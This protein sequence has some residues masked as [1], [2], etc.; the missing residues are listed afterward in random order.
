MKN[1]LNQYHNLVPEDEKLEWADVTNLSFDFWYRD[2]FQHSIQV[3]RQIKLKAIEHRHLILRAD[4]E[5]ALIKKEVLAS[6]MFY[7]EDWKKL[8]DA[9][10]QR[11]TSICSLYTNGCVHLLQLE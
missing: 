11:N 7:F 9:V 2:K 3:P 6:Y 8:T 1:L 5:I 4:E 10:A